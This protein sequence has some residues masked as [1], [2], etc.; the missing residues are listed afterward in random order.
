M[1][2]PEKEPKQGAPIENYCFLLSDF[3]Y[4]SL[5]QLNGIRYEYEKISISG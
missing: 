1:N 2:S 5:K 3:R 4:F